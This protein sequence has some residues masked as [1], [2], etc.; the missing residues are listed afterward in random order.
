MNRQPLDET[1]ENNVDASNP[2][3]GGEDKF[4]SQ[5]TND[6]HQQPQDKTLD[7]KR[8]NLELPEDT[9]QSIEQE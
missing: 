7:K 2:L 6:P 4:I 8:E 9:N 1:V 5:Q 3:S